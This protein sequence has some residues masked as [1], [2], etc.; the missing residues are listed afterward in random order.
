MTSNSKTNKANN[1]AGSKAAANKAN[2]AA[3]PNSKVSERLLEAL[4]NP[5]KNRILIEVSEQG[6]ATAK[7]LAQKHG[8]IPQATL[9]RYLKKM[10]DD[11][12]LE[13]VETRQVR[14]VT[15]KIYSLAVDLEADIEKMIEENSGEAYFKLFQQFTIGLLKEFHVYSQK[16]NIDLLNDGSGFRVTSINA[17]LD[18]ITQ[19]SKD[20]NALIA[21]YRE[22]EATPDR[23]ARSLAVIFTPPTGDTEGAADGSVDTAG[24]E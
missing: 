14:N 17:S 19:L 22:N 12:I 6:R 5:I 8:N 21:P 18:E 20:I 16:E 24:E 1:Q 23:Q 9:Y 15:E 2:K 13:I 3:K 10:T 11:G 4:T 7:T